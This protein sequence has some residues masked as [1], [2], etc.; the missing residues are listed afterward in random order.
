MCWP[1]TDAG[2][3]NFEPI[4]NAKEKIVEE[5]ISIAVLIATLF[6]G[7]VVAEKVFVSVRHAALV[8]AAEGLPRLSPFAAKLSHGN[9]DTIGRSKLKHTRG[10]ASSVQR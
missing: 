2:K 8:K 10:N 9:G 4:T 1:F 3:V 7:T 5:L 6:G